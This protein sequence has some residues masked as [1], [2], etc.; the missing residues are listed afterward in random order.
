[1]QDL[2]G[3]PLRRIEGGFH[4]RT[5]SIDW[6]REAQ[7]RGAIRKRSWTHGERVVV[8]YE[9]TATGCGFGYGV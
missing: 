6:R 7:R 2:A 3:W 9:L 4:L 1:L 5:A 8:E